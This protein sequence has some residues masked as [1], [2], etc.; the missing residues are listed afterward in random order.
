MSKELKVVV[1]YV[2]RHGFV[3]ARQKKHMIFKRG[4]HTLTVSKTP[5]QGFSLQ[6]AK[7][8]IRKCGIEPLPFN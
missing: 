4:E 6:Y 5:N 3:L 1:E 8:E 2:E 7:R